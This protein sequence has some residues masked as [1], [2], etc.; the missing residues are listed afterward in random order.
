M[1]IETPD[2]SPSEIPWTEKYRPHRLEELLSNQHV[3]T[4]I[5][6][7]LDKGYLPNLLF[8]GSPG[9]GKTSTILATAK[10]LYRSS[11]RYMVL[12]LNASDDRGYQLFGRPFVHLPKQSHLCRVN[13]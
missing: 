4:T 12:E 5:T 6:S 13:K 10:Q 7:Y 2:K 9:T 1:I 8:Y 11:F 3:I